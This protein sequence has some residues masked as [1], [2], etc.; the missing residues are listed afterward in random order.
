M[1]PFSTCLALACV[2]LLPQS[3]PGVHRSATPAPQR[4]PL[5]VLVPAYFYPV[6]NSPW[7][8]LTAKAAQWP[9]RVWAIG[10]PFNGPGPS[11]D[12]TYAQ[13]FQAFR[14]AGGRLLGYVSTSY[15]NVPAAQA[16]ADIDQWIAWY[17]LD[18]FFLD[19]MDNVPG[20]HEA[21]YQGLRDHARVRLPGALVVSNPGTSTVESYLLSSGRPVV[22]TLCVFENSTSFPAWAPDAW[23][24]RWRSRNFY[25]LPYGVGA[26]QWH[27][28]VDHAL[29][30]NCGWIY[31]TDDV[32][33]NPW[34]TLPA[35]FE[36]FVDDV[37]TR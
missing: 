36:A 12:A 34:D 5:R 8:R 28:C 21:Y 26:T 23:T 16:R 33:P 18:G 1:S 32:L 22:D 19:E 17:P 2:A 13:T 6:A 29:A 9:G 15:G 25:V 11:F 14:Q 20:A 35:Y 31:V 3:V 27:A 24:S 30:S 7:V 37:L 4:A 10:D